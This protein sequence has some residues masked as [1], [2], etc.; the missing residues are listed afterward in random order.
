LPWI[1][2]DL[3]REIRADLWRYLTPAASI[4]QAVLEAAALLKLPSYEL[5]TLG[6]IEFLVSPELERL[7]EEL[8][9]LTR[10]LATTTAAEEEWSA[11]RVRGAIQWGRT[12]G[13]RQATGISNLYITAPARRAYQTP[14]N[15]ML[16]LLLDAVVRL[17]RQVGWYGST[18]A[19]AGALV[20][21]RVREAQRWLQLR[22]LLEVERRPLTSSKLARIRA[23]RHR[24]RYT[25]AIAA[26][27]RYR[28]LAERLN[29]AAIRAAVEGY[30]LVTREDPTLFELLCTF[31]T[32][33]SLRAQG[34]ALSRLGLFAGLLRMSGKRGEQQ[35]EL[36]YQAVPKGLSKGSAYGAVQRSHGINPGAL[37]PD[38]VVKLTNGKAARWLLIEVKGGERH[39]VDSARAAAYDLLAYRT[40]FAPQLDAQDGVYGLGIAWGAEL[41]PTFDTGICLCTPD[42]LGAALAVLTSADI[43]VAVGG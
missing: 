23:G 8:P 7:L 14:E 20:S 27:E 42:T 6:R 21:D 11:E 25:S 2:S 29:R 26:Y 17:G 12:I 1:R 43:D 31:R 15:E 32:I 40:A 35:L 16:V 37:R 10:R 33:E 13:L 22:A 9:L 18:S 24:R 41:E 3:I 5:R 34:W 36:A 38:L 19:D 30:G 28:Q 4:E 39:V